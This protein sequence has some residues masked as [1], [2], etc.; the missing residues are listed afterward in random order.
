MSRKPIIDPKAADTL[1]RITPDTRQAKTRGRPDLPFVRGTVF[2]PR[3]TYARLK[4]QAAL[5]QT[6][7]QG[8]FE[9]AMDAWLAAQGEPPFFPADWKGWKVKDEGE[10]G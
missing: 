6:S 4:A 5:R 7:V 3:D 9:E 10:T 1:S 8:L 2:I